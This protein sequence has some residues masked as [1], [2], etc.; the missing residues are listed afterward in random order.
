MLCGQDNGRPSLRPARLV[1]IRS[2]MIVDYYCLLVYCERKILFWLQI[3]DHLQPS[4]QAVYQLEMSF[5][6]TTTSG[7]RAPLRARVK[8]LRLLHDGDNNM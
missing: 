8:D 7:W 2:Y 3:Y 4:E 6:F 1:L 5:D